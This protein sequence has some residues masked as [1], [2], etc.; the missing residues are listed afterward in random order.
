MFSKPNWPEQAEYV[1][2][3]LEIEFTSI[4]P[5]QDIYSNSQQ[6][7]NL[8]QA[9]KSILQHELAAA[10]TRG[11]LDGLMKSTQEETF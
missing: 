1:A 5:A 2:Q 3:L 10:Y 8:A 7:F 9:A 4:L 11:V 6:S